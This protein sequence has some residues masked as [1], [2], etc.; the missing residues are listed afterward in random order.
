MR[1]LFT[2][3]KVGS[4][5]LRNR[6]SMPAIHH[7]YS[8][9]GHVNDRL[10]KYYETRAK[11]GAALIIVGGCTIDKIG[12]GPLMIGLHDDEYIE[13]LQKL[14]G[15][16]KSAG[17]K[18]AAQLYQA[19]RYTHSFFTGQQALAPSPIAS[20]LTREVPREMTTDD[21]KMVIESFGEAALRAKKSGFDAVEIIASAGYLICQFLSP[22]TN[23]RTDSYG[24]SWANRCRFGIEV[25]KKV[26]EKVGSDF[27]IMVRLSGNDFMPGSN[28][29]K[30]AAMF[31]AELE[32]AGVD[33]FNVTGGWHET[34]VPQITGDLPSGG[35]AYLAQ[36]VKA[37][38]T[39]PVIASNRINDPL[40][41]EEIL[42]S[43]QAD[44]VNIG[45]PMIADPEFANKA[46]SGNVKS[47]R[48]CLACNQGCMDMV[49]SAQDVHCAVNPMAGREHEISVDPAPAARRVLVIGGGPAGME[50]A[51]TAASRGHHVTLWERSSRL[52]GQIHYAAAPPGKQEFLTLVGYYEHVLAEKGVK[53]L[54]N[55]EATVDNVTSENADVVIIATGAKPAG[56]PFSVT[57]PDKVYSAIE[58]LGGTAVLG[59]E[60]V[61]IGG[62]AVGCETALSIAE[63]G[64]INA[65][66]L[67]FLMEN[68]AESYETL[69]KLLN[70]GNKNVTIVEL[71]K[72]I[73]RD[74]GKSTRWVVMKNIKR[75][76]I[77]VIDQ[78]GVKEVNEGGVV[79]ER[80]GQESLIPADSVVL[81]VGAK[82]VNEL[83]SLLGGKVPELHLI[84]DASKP[85][86]VTEAIREGFE[87][88]IKI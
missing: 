47:I 37:A 65:D 53:V 85:R 84:G 64:T 5:E 31:A 29:N 55:Q 63:M 57:A 78:A 74:I 52:G 13:G 32:K 9:G 27:T 58:V 79:I 87:L 21:I 36:G 81:A 48:K 46:M 69:L 68:E 70:R 26:R 49:F 18:I 2:P 82:S 4:M 50:A 76:G 23:Q 39:V 54:L 42:R 12:V 83:F 51:F 88:A 80:E 19:G 33:C 56:A 71:L 43:G 3:I 75:L 72:G 61:V 67:K 60:V 34:R 41:A 66:T 77:N 44:M 59:R 10:I 73:G 24:G 28:T 16:V 30:E 6:I 8:P 1:L 17:A 25:V 11:G 35:F 22:I 40:L 86:K 38:V 7:C 20:Q 14:T 62:G 15:A 45:R